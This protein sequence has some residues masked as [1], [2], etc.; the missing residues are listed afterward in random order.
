MLKVQWSA[1]GRQFDAAKAEL[2]STR[3][4]FEAECSLA[5]VQVQAARHRE[6]IS[7]FSSLSSVVSGDSITT[8]STA[9]NP[10]F[11]GRDDVLSKLHSIFTPSFEPRDASLRSRRSCLIHGIGGMGKT[12]TAV[13]YT[14]RYR[15][16]YKYI[17]WLKA[18]SNVTLSESF[19]N[20]T[21]KIG[22]NQN[23]TLDSKIEEGLE[24]FQTTGDVQISENGPD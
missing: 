14:Y 5:N 16:C 20:A 12:E 24:W 7:S 15:S 18:Q 10:V 2:N 22:L 9:Q 11:T 13:E 8:V 17:F 19:I 23:G 6:V 1:L 21:R 3:A 4:Y